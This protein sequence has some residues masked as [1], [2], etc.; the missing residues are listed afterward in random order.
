MLTANEAQ[1]LLTV[2]FE[3]RHLG[4]P[5]AIDT[6]LAS[7]VTDTVASSNS[8]KQLSTGESRSF[9]QLIEGFSDSVASSF[10]ATP[11]PGNGLSAGEV[12]LFMQQPRPLILAAN[13]QPTPVKPKKKQQKER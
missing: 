8:G 5:R 4:L 13:N 2:N 7:G 3:S 10:G 11:A 12:P 6:A 1:G 9:S